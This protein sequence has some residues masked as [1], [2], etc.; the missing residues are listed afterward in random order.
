MNYWQIA[1][2]D[3]QTNFILCCYLILVYIC[4][5]PGIPMATDLFR[6]RLPHALICFI[7]NHFKCITLFKNVLIWSMDILQWY[8]ICL[9]CIRPE[10]LKHWIKIK[11]KMQIII[12]IM[13]I[14]HYNYTIYKAN[15][16]GKNSSTVVYPN[17]WRVSV[18]Q[19]PC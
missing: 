18:S 6:E 4:Q 19:H 10:M 8:N 1:C 7:E 17:C 12:L 3:K 16:K 11:N 13:Y 5:D 15:Y 9:A 2:Q 14:I